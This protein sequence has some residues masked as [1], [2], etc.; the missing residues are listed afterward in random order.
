V[1]A[2]IAAS[3]QDT[4]PGAPP[5]GSGYAHVPS[6][7][8]GLGLAP[9]PATPAS[10]SSLAPI[11]EPVRSAAGQFEEKLVSV[12][13]SDM[14]RAKCIASVIKAVQT[15]S[16]PLVSMCSSVDAQEQAEVSAAN[17]L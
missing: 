1:A 9:Q 7:G 5:A 10:A 16:R 17:V 8:T 14:A 11:S 4:G 15:S 13:K 3:L 12:R 2:A 6:G